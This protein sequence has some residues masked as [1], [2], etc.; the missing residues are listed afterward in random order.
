MHAN[1]LEAL[2]F[3]AFIWSRTQN[4]EMLLPGF[5]LGLP[6]LINIIKSVPHKHIHQ[7]TWSTD[8]LKVILS[9]VKLTVK[10]N[11]HIYTHVT[12]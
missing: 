7:P 2:T 1:E 9:F 10:I 5:R 3:S 8:S 4:Q 6:T 11:N 12:P